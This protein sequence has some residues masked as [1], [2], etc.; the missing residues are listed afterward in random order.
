MSNSNPSF[1]GQDNLAGDSKALF[2]KVF[3]GE[4]L[5]AFKQNTVA[6]NRTRSRTISHGK[7]ASFAATGRT[8]ATYHTPGNEILGKNIGHSERVIAIDDLLISDVFIANIDEAM[9]E[10]DVRSI[11]SSECGQAL[12]V[13]MDANILQ[14]GVLAARAA[15]AIASLPGGS[16]LI[17]ANYKTD[18]SALAG[19]LFLGA[20]TLDEKSVAMEGRTA[21]MRPAQYYLLA[22]NTTAINTLYG[23]QGAYSDGTVVRIAGVE[24]VKSLQLPTTN[25]VTGPAKYQVNASTT[26][27]LI[28]SAEAVGTVQLMGLALEQDYDIRRQGTLIVA[29][30]AVGHGILRAEAA[31]ELKTA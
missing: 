13:A 17:N 16:S 30:Y 14:T 5:S 7:S 25:I 9:S 18:S 10:Y 15:N 19:G 24:L 26:A 3:T 12:A 8:S 31:V 29:K 20:Q 22:Q 11:Y 6:L 28:M 1:V 2:Y 27:A 23:G 4:V 21:Y